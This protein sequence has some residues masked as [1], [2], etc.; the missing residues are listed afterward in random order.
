MKC[1]EESAARLLYSLIWFSALE[2]LGI[3]CNLMSKLEVDHEWK[4]YSS[5]ET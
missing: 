2:P 4:C 1:S 3:Y 5:H